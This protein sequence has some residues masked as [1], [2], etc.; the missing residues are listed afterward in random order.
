MRL[1]KTLE[2]FLISFLFLSLI[3]LFVTVYAST[4]VDIKM[5]GLVANVDS[6][7][8]LEV[9]PDST[10]K[11]LLADV[12]FPVNE[13]EK[14]VSIE[15]LK[16]R[17]LDK[18]IYI[19]L[20]DYY[21][22]DQRNQSA[23]IIFL[24]YN[25][26]HLMNINKYLLD[27]H[28]VNLNDTINEFNPEN[29]ILFTPISEIELENNYREIVLSFYSQQLV[30]QGTRLFAAA[31]A[32][33]IFISNIIKITPKSIRKIQFWLFVIIS[34]ILLGLTI[35]VVG[36]IFYYG[37]LTNGVTHFPF[38]SENYPSQIDYQIAIDQY[39]YRG[40]ISNPITDDPISHGLGSP[41]KE[42]VMIFSYSHSF[43]V[44]LP[45]CLGIDLLFSILFAYFFGSRNFEYYQSEC[46]ENFVNWIKRNLKQ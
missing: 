16:S 41:I 36:R 31:S 30:S 25:S 40:G 23:S 46:L 44:G 7:G 3:S 33:F 19:D 15:R 2:L 6:E 28:F 8:N 35:F 27:N 20:D 34:M 13:S 32:S 5:R 37:N 42:I 4:N 14:L 17:I 18:E 10:I 12:N 22:A 9:F 43:T 45:I 38:S 24:K 26:T 1:K 21:R 39:L 11:F 29:W